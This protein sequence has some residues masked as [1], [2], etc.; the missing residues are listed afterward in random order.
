MITAETVLALE[1][2][3]KRLPP[4]PQVSVSGIG[5]CSQ[6][7]SSMGNTRDSTSTGVNQRQFYV[8]K[9]VGEEVSFI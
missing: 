7:D 3:K 8:S 2:I 5:W 6:S 9:D 4:E 1:Y